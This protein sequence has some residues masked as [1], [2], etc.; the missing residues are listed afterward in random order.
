MGLRNENNDEEARLL[1]N[2]NSNAPSSSSSSSSAPKYR[3]IFGISQYDDVKIGDD[4]RSSIVNQGN[5][6]SSYH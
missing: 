1:G 6:A 2:E 3:S 5:T 4:S